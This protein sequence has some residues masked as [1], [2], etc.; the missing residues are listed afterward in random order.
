MDEVLLMHN[1]ELQNLWGDIN[2][3]GSHFLLWH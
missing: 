3:K 1:I 2:L